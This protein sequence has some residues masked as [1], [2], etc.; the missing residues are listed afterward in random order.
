MQFKLQNKKFK[1]HINIIRQP[2]FSF[3]H[4]V[5]YLIDLHEMIYKKLH[6]KYYLILIIY[7]TVLICNVKIL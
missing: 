3:D 7:K 4:L 5:F 1:L 6:L 2:R